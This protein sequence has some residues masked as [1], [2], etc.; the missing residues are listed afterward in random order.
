[1]FHFFSSDI[2]VFS[3]M[4][5]DGSSCQL[6]FPH[7]ESQEKELSHTCEDLSGIYIF[8]FFFN[9]FLK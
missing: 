6:H 3:L 8:Y 1:M 4:K 9:Q 7:N 5:T 2:R